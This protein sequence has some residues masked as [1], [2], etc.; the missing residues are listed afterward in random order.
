MITTIMSFFGSIKNFLIAGTAIVG[1]LYVAKQKFNAYQ[2]ESKLQDIETKIAKVNV[3]VAV[4]KAKAKA[5]S[6]KIETDTEVE[7]LRELKVEKNKVQ[8]EMQ[9]IEKDIEDSLKGKIQTSGRTR[10]K[11]IKVDI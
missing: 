6:K 5:K 1:G 8:K 7:I 11:K 2:A 4:E 10:G 3:K 9:V